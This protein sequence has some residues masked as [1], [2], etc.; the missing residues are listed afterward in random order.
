MTSASSVS[1]FNDACARNAMAAPKEWAD[2]SLAPDGFRG[3]RHAA[4]LPSVACM[5]A[6]VCAQ[7]LTKE[8][9]S[10]CH[11]HHLCHRCS[12]WPSSPLNPRPEH[13]RPA[14]AHIQKLT[15]RKCLTRLFPVP[16][17]LS[18]G[19]AVASWL[20][21]THTPRGERGK[22]DRGGGGGKRPLSHPLSNSDASY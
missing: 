14:P 21:A 4:R 15:P 10:M 9:V 8:A 18:V 1:I 22:K 20:Q 5:L 13:P 2:E 12:P 6:C 19:S 3:H 11:R 17:A 7:W 16:R